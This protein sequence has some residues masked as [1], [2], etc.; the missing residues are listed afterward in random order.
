LDTFACTENGLA[1]TL[2]FETVHH[3]S[4][5][6]FSLMSFATTPFFTGCAFIFTLRFTAHP[7]AQTF[8]SFVSI[9]YELAPGNFWDTVT[10]TEKKSFGALLALS[11]AV[12]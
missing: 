2:F 3:F 1:S 5:L 11:L 9:A 6:H 4:I 7:G 8:L 10:G 12:H